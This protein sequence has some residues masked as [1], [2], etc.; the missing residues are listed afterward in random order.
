MIKIDKSLSERKQI[1]L[2]YFRDRIT[3]SLEEIIRTHGTKQYKKQAKEINKEIN[4]TEEN[5]VKNLLQEAN[6]EKWSNEDILKCILMINYT[7]NV[8]MIENRND[9]WLYEYM[10]FS[11]RIGEI[12]EHFCKLCFDFPSKNIN[13]FIPPRFSEIKQKLSQEIED[14][15]VHLNITN[16]Q[17]IDLKR[18]YEK[19]WS[20]VTSGEIKL[21][22]DLHFELNNKLINIDFKSGFGSNEKGNTNRLLLVATIYKNLYENYK[23]VILVRANEDKNNNYFQIL[24]NSEVWEAYCGNEAYDKIKEY[25]GF[26]IKQWITEHINWENDF[27]KETIQYLRKNDLDKYLKW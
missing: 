25:S 3:E 15:I 11:R 21:E 14:Y 7:K 8:V 17:K 23:C 16:E 10:T 4:K 9:V 19:V 5:L 12:W 2:E 13:L 20:L 24:K 18:Y 26:D 27:K 6:K 22:L 1:L